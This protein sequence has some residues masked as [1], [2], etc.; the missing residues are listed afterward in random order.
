MHIPHN[1]I[2]RSPE[3]LLCRNFRLRQRHTFLETLGRAQYDPKNENFIPLKTLVEGTDLE[4]CT[5]YAKC[6]IND[7]NDFLKT[8]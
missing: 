6:S 1:Q 8:L 2:K 4:F 3:V 7:F 5:K